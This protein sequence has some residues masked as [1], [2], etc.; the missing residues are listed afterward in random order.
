MKLQREDKA[1]LA[2][3]LHD[4]MRVEARS[5][6]GVLS[7]PICNRPFGHMII[8]H[9]AVRHVGAGKQISFLFR[10]YSDF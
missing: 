1:Q 3:T 10:V 8:R 4:F 5:S 2:H 7:R 9:R 6:Y